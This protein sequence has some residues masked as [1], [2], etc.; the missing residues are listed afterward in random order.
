[1][2][3]CSY[4]NRGGHDVDNCFA[5]NGYPEWWEHRSRR[6]GRGSDRGRRGGSMAP[7]LGAGRGRVAE[8]RA[9]SS[10]TLTGG[11]HDVHTQEIKSS[12]ALAISSDQWQQLISL[13]GNVGVRPMRSA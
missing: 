1:M 12:G 3:V 2:L 6:S 4:C 10:G 11:S 13:L 5:K 8:V 7:F 9:V